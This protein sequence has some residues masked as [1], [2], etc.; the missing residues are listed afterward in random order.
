MKKNFF[1]ILLLN[2]CI[3]LTV[4]L[5]YSEGLLNL[6]PT[7]ASLLRAGMSIFVGIA[8]A[9]AFVYGNYS[10]LSDNKPKVL[11]GAGELKD[12]NQAREV[13]RS[14]HGGNYFGRIADTASDQM[15]R[16]ERTMNRA[17]KAIGLKFDKDTMAYDRYVSTI[18]AA[19][20]AALENCIAMAN[21]MQLFDEAEYGSIQYYKNDRIPDEIQEKQAAIYQQN[22][23]Q[24]QSAVAANEKLILALDTM[25]LELA[26]S[27][28]GTD[29]D[30]QEAN[31]LEEIKKLTDQVRLYT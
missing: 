6:R 19:R 14:F 23:D 8:A 18:Q 17:D 22:M 5:C 3:V 26:G 30:V 1:K 24:I 4:V 16:L 2:F 29:E 31:L 20:E 11:Y 28:E 7:D 21:R 12:I 9:V 15:L 13:L 25:S 27:K 10:L